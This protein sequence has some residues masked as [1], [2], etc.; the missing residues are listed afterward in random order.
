M[1]SA[2]KR[3]PLPV[4]ALAAVI[5]SVSCGVIAPDNARLMELNRNGKWKEAERI[6]LDMLR[7]QDNFSH[8]Q[9][10]E[11]FFQVAYAKTRQGK[12]SE[13]VDLMKEYDAFSAKERIDPKLLWLGR[14]TAKLK[15]ELGMLDETQRALVAA[16]EENGRGNFAKARELCE[17]LLSAKEA[18][19]IQ[20]A[21]AHF[22]AAVCSIR[23]KDASGA[24]AHLA[25]FEAL[26][27]ALPPGH[28]AL[29]EEAAALQGLDELRRGPQGK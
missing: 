8:S 3:R 7:H 10:C 19:D 2:R 14:E 20:R 17:G 25:A 15:E 29:V 5:A 24:E 1:N 28:Q 9:S 18:N 27:S 4:I 11:T 12:K 13:A 6:G 26:K 23:L 21:T 16:M 22:V